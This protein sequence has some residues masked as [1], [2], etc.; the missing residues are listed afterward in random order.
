VVVVLPP[1]FVVV[2]VDFDFDPDDEW[3]LDDFLVADGLDEPQA[4]AIRPPTATTATSRSDLAMR[5]W[6][7]LSI[8][9]V[10]SVGFCTMV[11]LVPV[12]SLGGKPPVRKDPRAP[13]T[14]PAG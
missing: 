2:V 9:G 3:L 12:S 1:V 8:R 7:A 5:R 13:S 10:E 11:F 14:P 6:L 4:A